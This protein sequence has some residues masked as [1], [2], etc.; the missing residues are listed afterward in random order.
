MQLYQ[1]LR[2]ANKPPAE[3]AVYYVTCHY[4][5]IIEHIK[6]SLTNTTEFSAYEYELSVHHIHFYK[7][8][9]S[10]AYV[11]LCRMGICCNGPLL[12]ERG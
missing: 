12:E 9:Y 11:A 2:A 10:N 5:S 4:T 8:Y 7:S 1:P 3:P 6:K